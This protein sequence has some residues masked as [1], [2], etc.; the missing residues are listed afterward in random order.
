MSARADLALLE[1]S[2]TMWVSL[3]ISPDPCVFKLTLHYFVITVLPKDEAKDSI[4]QGTNN[5]VRPCHASVRS[6][7]V[8]RQRNEYILHVIVIAAP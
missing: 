5:E 4:D 2:T 7:C 3:D 8:Q 6:V 1:R